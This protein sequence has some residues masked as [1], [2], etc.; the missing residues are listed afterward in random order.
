MSAMQI[1]EHKCDGKAVALF[2]CIT[3]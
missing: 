3:Y 2:V 1:A